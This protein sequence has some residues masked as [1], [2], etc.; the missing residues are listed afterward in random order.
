MF[1]SDLFKVKIS[2]RSCPRQFLMLVFCPGA[3]HEFMPL[4]DVEKFA[5]FRH[6]YI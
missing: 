3:D 6:L 1:A 5:I 4:R 2:L